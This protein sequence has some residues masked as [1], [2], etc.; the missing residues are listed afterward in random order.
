MVSGHR[1][2]ATHSGHWWNCMNGH[3]VITHPITSEQAL[4]GNSLQSANVECQWNLLVV[5]NVALQL[6]DRGT[7]LLME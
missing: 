3:P 6:E 5:P 2:I 4:T 7:Q 1:G